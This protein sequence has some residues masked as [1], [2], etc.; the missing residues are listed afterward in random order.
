MTNQPLTY[1]D[2]IATVDKKGD[3]IWL[4]PKQPVGA[5][6]QWRSWISYAYLILF[7]SGPFIHINGQ[8]LLML[9][10]LERKF[11]ILGQ[12][13]WPQDLYLFAMAMITG[14][15]FVV[16]FTIIY[17]RL[18]CGWVCPQT[19]FMELVFRKIEYFIEGDRNAQIKLSRSPWTKEKISKK[20]T[21]NI[22]FWVISFVIANTFLAYI[23]GINEWQKNI[24]DPVKDHLGGFLALVVFT[25]VFYAVYARFREQV[26]TTVCPYGRL[27]GVLLDKNSI[28]I[29]YDHQRGENRAKLKKG[30]NKLQVCP[31]GID[32]RD[33]LQ[34]ECT[35]CTAC[36]DACNNI[37][38]KINRPKGLIRYASLNELETGEP[39]KFT[40][41]VKAYS[42][43]LL[44]LLGIFGGLLFSIEPIQTTVLRTRGTLYSSPTP[45]TYANI[46]DISIINK[47]QEEQEINVQ[48]ADDSKGEIKIIGKPFI[49]SNNNELS[50]KFMV[51]LNKKATQKV[52][53]QIKINITDRDDKLIETIETNF[54]TPAL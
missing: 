42:A 2:K 28:N 15:I 7:F 34:M 1:R 16:L 18:F 47:T 9:N 40:N 13:F 36:I 12:V 49:I 5:F 53:N 44:V 10:I 45:T 11:S 51:V 52:R 14:I 23:I 48:L 33:G 22:L 32:I 54:I 21:K 17:G 37:M 43:L 35:N 24:T 19:I 27:Q 30:Q 50:S 20:V 6:Y 4:F 38:E 26:C 3:R 46:Y 8:P 25:S 41:R 39:F 31:T 29:A